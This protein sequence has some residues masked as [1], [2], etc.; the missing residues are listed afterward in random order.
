MEDIFQ[1][2]SKGEDE[3]LRSLLSS[4]KNVNQQLEAHKHFTIAHHAASVGTCSIV[5]QVL[6]LQ[7]IDLTVKDDNGKSPLHIAVL[8]N[9]S[10]HKSESIVQLFLVAHANVSA[11]DNNKQT[12]LHI[13]MLNKD[14]QSVRE[15]VEFEAPTDVLDK[16]LSSPM[17]LSEDLES[18][19]RF[20]MNALPVKSFPDANM[21]GMSQE[22][23]IKSVQKAWTM[24]LINK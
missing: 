5:K 2:I 8:Q 9:T 20:Y 23:L 22:G 19:F 10:R 7:S 15:L 24:Q 21:E 17:S 11:V 12:P 3:S 6:A 4:L 18:T 16:N 14:I 13:A 1:A